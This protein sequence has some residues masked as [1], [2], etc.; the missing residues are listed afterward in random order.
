MEESSAITPSQQEKTPL[1]LAWKVAY[2][3]DDLFTSM[4]GDDKGSFIE[5][6][7]NTYLFDI[8]VNG[9]LAVKQMQEEFSEFDEYEKIPG[10]IVHPLYIASSYAVQAINA[11]NSQNPEDIKLAWGYVVEAHY[12]LGIL[13]G[14]CSLRSATQH[15]GRKVQDKAAS[16]RHAEN[17][18]IKQDVW[19]YYE[20]NIDQFKSKDEAAEAIAKTVAP[21]SFR[22]IRSYIDQ[23]HKNKTVS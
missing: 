21:M 7:F 13:E 14:I 12:W 9:D 20:K 8:T 6:C 4:C 22:T 3:L 11:Y 1:T 16:V 17:R 5:E 23:F 18:A 19:D 10:G 15:L 2:Q